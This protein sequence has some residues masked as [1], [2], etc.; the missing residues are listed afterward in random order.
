MREEPLLIFNLNVRKL[1]HGETNHL[2]KVTNC[3]IGQGL[4]VWAVLNVITVTEQAGAQ[5]HGTVTHDP[6]ISVEGNRILFTRFRPQ[7]DWEHFRSEPFSPR[8]PRASLAPQK[9]I[10]TTMPRSSPPP[11]LFL[12]RLGKQVSILSGRCTCGSQ[13]PHP[14]AAAVSSRVWGALFPA[15]V[16]W[17]RETRAVLH[18]VVGGGVQAGTVPREW[19]LCTSFREAEACN[20]AF[21]ATVQLQASPTDLCLVRQVPAAPSALP[22]ASPVWPSPGW[23]SPSSPS[24][25]RGAFPCLSHSLRPL[26]FVGDSLFHS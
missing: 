7:W 16:Q 17:F 5:P 25:P 19:L 12:S 4:K 3:Y 14:L 20:S 2:Y 11:H 26:L 10:S 23:P 22:Q 8:R 1:P 6:T 9:A 13:S 21:P 18:W 15:S 24:R